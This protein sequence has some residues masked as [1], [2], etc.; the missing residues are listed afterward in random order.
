MERD[1]KPVLPATTAGAGARGGM[2]FKP[3]MVRKKPVVRDSD[4]EDD[5]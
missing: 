2:K 5:E 1:T 3:N 4:D